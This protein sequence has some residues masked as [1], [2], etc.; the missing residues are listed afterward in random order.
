MLTMVHHIITDT[1]LTCKKQ[2][3]PNVNRIH[4]ILYTT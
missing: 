2:L 1:T 4:I 3:E